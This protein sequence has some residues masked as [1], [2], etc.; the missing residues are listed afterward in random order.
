[1][2]KTKEEDLQQKARHLCLKM[3]KIL[4]PALKYE[5]PKIIVTSI[6]DLHADLITFLLRD[7][8]KKMTEMSKMLTTIMLENDGRSKKV[9]RENIREEMKSKPQKQMEISREYMKKATTNRYE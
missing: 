1:M 9:I 2:K 5:D 3:E 4:H 7:D 8:T 6:I